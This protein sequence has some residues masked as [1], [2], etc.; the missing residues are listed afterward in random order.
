MVGDE[1][2]GVQLNAIRDFFADKVETIYLR[3]VSEEKVLMED[4]QSPAQSPSQSQSPSVNDGCT[5]VTEEQNLEEQDKEK[6]HKVCFQYDGTL[7]M[8][9]EVEGD[10]RG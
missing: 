7:V 1:D 4:L 2:H 10:V 6:T 8:E 3:D 9:L 5:A